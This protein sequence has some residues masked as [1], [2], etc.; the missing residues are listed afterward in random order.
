[1]FHFPEP[2]ELHN[3]SGIPISDEDAYWLL[4][5]SGPLLVATGE[6]EGTEDPAN[7]PLLAWWDLMNALPRDLARLCQKVVRARCGGQLP[8]APWE[9]MAP[10]GT[11]L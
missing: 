3:P 6:S 10:D 7:G 8:A 1:M 9:D 4:V 2:G 11:P 5:A